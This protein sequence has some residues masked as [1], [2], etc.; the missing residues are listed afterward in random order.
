MQNKGRYRVGW[1]LVMFDLPVDTEKERRLANKFRN[2]LLDRGYLMLQYSVYARCAVT[3]ER[4]KH[5]IEELKEINPGTGNIHCI[6]FTD[7]QWKES[8]ILHKKDTKSSRQ[9]DIS[10]DMQNQM[11]FW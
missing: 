6:F 10:D 1:L 7:A 5:L 2:D 9:I 8:I 4:K 11:Q 3:L